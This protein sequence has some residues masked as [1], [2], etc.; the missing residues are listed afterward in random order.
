[1]KD[2]ERINEVIGYYVN[3]C[4]VLVKELGIFFIY[5]WFKMQGIDGW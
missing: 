3:Y 1:M 4:V 5:L 2:L